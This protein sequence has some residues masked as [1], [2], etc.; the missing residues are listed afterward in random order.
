MANNKKQI[1]NN[2]Q[3]QNHNKKYS[4]MF[5]FYDLKL[6]YCLRFDAWDL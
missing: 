1:S 4:N 2:K 5:Y 6:W 3:Y